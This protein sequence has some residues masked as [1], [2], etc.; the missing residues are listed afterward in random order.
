MLSKERSE[1]L[2]PSGSEDDF[3][4]GSTSLS[5][6]DGILMVPHPQKLQIWT[7]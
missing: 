7:V 3:G 2:L 5:E 4:G 1:S 6:F